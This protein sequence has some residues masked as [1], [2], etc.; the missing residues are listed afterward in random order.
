MDEPL[1]STPA[2]D[3]VHK[4]TD[5]ST[6]SNPK[7]GNVILAQPVIDALISSLVSSTEPVNIEDNIARE[8]VDIVGEKVDENSS[9]PSAS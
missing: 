4:E 2:D 5:N 9:I 8:K 3:T 6:E 1:P 7:D